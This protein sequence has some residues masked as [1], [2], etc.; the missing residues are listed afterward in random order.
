MRPLTSLVSL[1]RFEQIVSL[2][3]AA[4]ANPLPS[5]MPLTVLKSGRRLDDGRTSA[6]LEQAEEELERELT[7][8]AI[9]GRGH[10]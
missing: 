5:P 10:F 9:A 1:L 7:R 4:V 3:D 6:L 8:C 2:T